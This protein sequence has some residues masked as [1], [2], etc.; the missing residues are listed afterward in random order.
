M[1]RSGRGGGI[2]VN[3]DGE[4]PCG[5]YIAAAGPG[6]LAALR[7]Q[8]ARQ[9]I[10]VRGNPDYYERDHAVFGVEEA[11]EL[12]ERASGRAI[13][14][15]RTFV[16]LA[17]SITAEAQN[18]LLKTLEE[19]PPG[20]RFFL[21]VPSPQML[22]A[23][24]RSRAQLL[25][26]VSAGSAPPES[27]V[28]VAAFL[29]APSRSRLAMLSPLLEKGEDDRRDLGAISVFLG[30]LE[31]ALAAEPAGLA[32]VYRARKY[33]SDRGAL[34]KPLLEQAALLVPRM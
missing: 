14:A 24:L 28:D 25:S 19:P 18:A 5:T 4:I 29:A 16:V 31:A 23:T 9:G 7:A 8:L 13:G 2:L 32:A 3:M 10:E 30:A 26:L 15:G 22:L 33:L 20:A 21:I 1:A 27:P 11:R 17:R 34:V 6:A 12:R